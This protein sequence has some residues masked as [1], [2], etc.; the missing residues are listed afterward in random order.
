M[1]GKAVALAA[2][3]QK[4]LV[5]QIELLDL[6]DALRQVGARVRFYNTKRPHHSLGGILVRADRFHGWQDETLRR[7]EECGAIGR[8]VR[9]MPVSPALSAAAQRITPR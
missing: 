8:P 9:T 7:L 2:A 6:C 5:R 3:M 4:E 1:N